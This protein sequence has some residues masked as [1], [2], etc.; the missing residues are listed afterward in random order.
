MNKKLSICTIGKIV[1]RY[2]FCT[3][4]T[5]FMKQNTQ[6]IIIPGKTFL[7]QVSSKKGE[8]TYYYNSR[9]E[10]TNFFN[11]H[12]KEMST[13]CSPLK[14]RHTWAREERDGLTIDFE[15][16]DDLQLQSIFELN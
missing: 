8:I 14:D 10:A 2:Y 16:I 13:E 5:L 1:E 9:V 11:K 3:F 7:V 15:K 6:R 4:N 12:C